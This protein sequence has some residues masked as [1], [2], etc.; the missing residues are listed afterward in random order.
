MRAARWRE[1]RGAPPMRPNSLHAAD[2][3]HLVHQQTDLGAHEAEG[4]ILIARG[5]GVHVTDT[6][7]REYIEAMAGLW[8][9]SLGF[10]ERRLAEAA[11]KQMLALPYYH[12]FFQKGH[13]PSVRLAEKLAPIAPPRPN[14]GLVQLSGAQAH[15]PA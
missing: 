6:E 4:A 14:H 15:Y 13:E 2:L 12:T 7:G 10:S 3:A 1:P 9:A 11:Y 5:N 8:C